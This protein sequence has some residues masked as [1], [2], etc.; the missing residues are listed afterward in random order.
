MTNRHGQSLQKNNIN[1]YPGASVAR[2]YDGLWDPFKYVLAK[3]SGSEAH[4]HVRSQFFA[5]FD[6]EGA[7]LVDATNAL[8]LMNREVVLHDIKCCPTYTNFLFGV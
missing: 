1:S 8:N 7:I 6:T 2:H 4:L 5:D 3:E